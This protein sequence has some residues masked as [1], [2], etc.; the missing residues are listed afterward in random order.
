MKT[1]R[2][3]FCLTMILVGSLSTFCQVNAVKYQMQYNKKTN[4]ADVYLVIHEGKATEMKHRVQF[5]AQISIVIPKGVSPLISKRYMPLNDNQKYNGTKPC[6]WKIKSN[7]LSPEATPNVDYYSIIPFLDP[8]SFYNNLKKG[9]KI[10]LFSIAVAEDDATKVSQIRLFTNGKDPASDANGMLG[11][12]F[13]QSFT[14]GSLTS[15]Y[16]GNAK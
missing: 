16:K 15:I 12:D 11:S 2:A 1:L 13:T 7:V 6:E 8:S 3:I 14:L 5:S 9:D 10:K 4:E